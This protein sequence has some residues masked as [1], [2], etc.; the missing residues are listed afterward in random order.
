MKINRALLI[1]TI[2]GFTS[3]SAL[4]ESKKNAWEGA[5]TQIGI[6][7][8]SFMTSSQSGTT[9]LPA[10]RF[11]GLAGTYDNKSK[12]NNANGI[13]ANISAGYSFGLNDKFVLGVGATY[14]PGASSA[15]SLSFTTPALNST[16]NGKYNVKNL[17]NLFLS[18]GY[19]IDKE[20]LTYAKVG[21][22]GGTVSAYAPNGIN[23]FPT[24]NVAIGGLSFGLGY[25]QMLTEKIYLL[26]EANYAMFNSTIASVVTNSGAIVNS[27][28]NGN[29]VDLL[30]GIGY[31]F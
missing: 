26:G 17:Y 6:G 2:T 31:R 3:N 5:Y 10:S 22:A 28:I 29:G 15:A 1:A 19:V 27:K 7:Y 30:V 8:E 21:Y 9:T 23:A 11:G 4:A 13:A 20:R 16:T 12:A 18:P 25:K 14:F 24:K